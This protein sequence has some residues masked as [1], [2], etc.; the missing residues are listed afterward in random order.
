MILIHLL[1]TETAILRHL[2]IVYNFNFA[3][4]INQLLNR[5]SSICSSTS[6]FF[7]MLTVV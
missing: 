4:V 5:T 6:I 2:E 7:L 3:R 1:M